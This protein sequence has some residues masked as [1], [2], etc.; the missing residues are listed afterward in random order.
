MGANLERRFLKG[1]W[2]L[3]FVAST[4]SLQ[5]AFSAEPTVSNNPAISNNEEDAL[6]QPLEPEASLLPEPKPSSQEV[7]VPQPDPAPTTLTSQPTVE[8]TPENQPTQEGSINSLESYSQKRKAI[9]EEINRPHWSFGLL[10]EPRAFSAT[11]WRARPIDHSVD[12][13]KFVGILLQGEYFLL[14]KFGLGGV[15]AEA[16]F[17]GKTADDNFTKSMPA[18]LTLGPYA[19]YQ[20]HYFTGQW[21]VPFLQAQVSGLRYRYSF[22]SALISGYKILPRFDAGLHIYLNFL[23]RDS[24]GDMYGNY[25]VLRTYLTGAFS[26]AKDLRQSKDMDL[27]EKTFRVGLR[28]EM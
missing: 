14:R 28:F 6:L 21:F 7:A 10:S 22:N 2:I 9:A 17:Y 15:G 24:A 11:E 26:F 27:S 18:V 8:S 16:G 23:D 20:F 25:G 4:F 1:P 13:A 5:V 12:N 3:A 19:S